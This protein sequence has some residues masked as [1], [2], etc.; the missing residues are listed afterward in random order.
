MISGYKI[1]LTVS[2]VDEILYD[3]R[4]GIFIDKFGGKCP[5]QDMETPPSARK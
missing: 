1:L 4:A 2:R 3:I 5:A